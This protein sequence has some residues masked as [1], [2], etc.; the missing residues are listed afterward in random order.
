MAA[1]VAAVWDKGSA[2]IFDVEVESQYFVA[3]WSIFAPGCG[4]FGGQRGPSRA[5]SPEA[6]PEVETS[7]ATFGTQAALYRL[8]GDRHLIHI[9]PDAARAIG[10][11]RPILHG[12]CTLAAAVLRIAAVL[13][14]HPAD[15][16]ELGGRFAA[17]VLPGQELDLALWRADAGVSFRAR[18]GGADVLV[19]GFARFATTERS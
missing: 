12:L 11:P 18:H 13:G 19:D 3:T 2:A 16:L 1:R 4:G 14:V 7:V 6:G 10:Q 9:D 5:Q 15:L 17:P 8:T